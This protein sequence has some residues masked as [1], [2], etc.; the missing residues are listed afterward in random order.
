MSEKPKI[1]ATCEAGCLWETVHKDDFMRSASIVRHYPNE[2]GTFVLE[3]EYKYKIKNAN[4]GDGTGMMFMSSITLYP[5]GSDKTYTDY[6]ADLPIFEDVPFY[7]YADGTTFRVLDIKVS[8]RGPTPDT[9][10]AYATVIYEVDGIQKEFTAYS[11]DDDGLGYFDS[12]DNFENISLVIY[13]A[14]ATDV[15]VYNEDAEILLDTTEAVKEAEREA[16]EHIE[17]MADETLD[18]AQTTGNSKTKAMS[19]DAVTKIAASISEHIVATISNSDASS[20]GYIDTSGAGVPYSENWCYTDYIPIREGTTIKSNEM[21]GQP[22]ILSLA[23]YDADKQLIS[24][25]M[26]DAWGRFVIDEV[27]PTDAKYVRFTFEKNDTNASIRIESWARAIAADDAAQIAAELDEKIVEDIATLG[28]STLT[29]DNTKAGVYIHT[30][31]T[32]QSVEQ[33]TSATDFIKVEPFS[34]V[35]IK[36][37]YLEGNRSIC[38]YDKGKNFIV[39]IVHHYDGKD[40][41]IESVPYNVDY[42][43][44]THKT[45]ILPVVKKFGAVS[46]ADI[47]PYNDI[48]IA[49]EGFESG[50]IRADGVTKVS[51]S[52]YSC[53][54]FIPVCPHQEIELRNFMSIEYKSFLCYDENKNFVCAVAADLTGALYTSKVFTIPYGV[55]Y[56]RVHA[57]GGKESKL[58][59]SYTKQI[60]P[61]VEMTDLVRDWFDASHRKIDKLF[62]SATAKPIITFIDD[63]TTS[64][65][66]V[67]RFRDV[68]KELGIRGTYACLPTCLDNDESGELANTLLEYEREGFHVTL[69]SY[70]QNPLYTEIFAKIWQGQTYT[71]EEWEVVEGDFVKGL[72]KLQEYGFTDF[73]FWVTPY[74]VSGGPFDELA[75]KWGMH[76]GVSISNNDYEST[77]MKR[78]KYSLNRASFTPDDNT[79]VPTMPELKEIIDRASQDNGWVMVGTHM[80]QEEW[81]NETALNRFRDLVNYAKSKG[82]EVKTLNE[83]WRIRE[84]IYRLYE[85]F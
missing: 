19:Q 58:G 20:V 68:C 15:F 50:Y 84:P 75:R 78:G 25:I 81:N 62:R 39:G 2:S 64:V 36:N 27:A 74:G 5:A 48:D 35:E 14:G 71:A 23:Y 76:C 73:K 29:V 6:Q 10:T 38:G 70:T 63:D 60:R 85:M 4:T 72:Q 33:S 41:T 51:S 7:K 77:I 79:S 30:N 1:F 12:I 57:Q 37:V 66:G 44:I 8:R 13:V 61:D 43:R 11:Q 28:V 49:V 56:I 46:K 59:I 3:P 83:A 82:F 65:A 32:E 53:S 42:I 31:G 54:D 21:L 22:N 47:F 17:S 69:H 55:H 16:V 26:R 45:D 67:K 40:Y 52:A 34:K 9:L 24:S 18:I 80:C